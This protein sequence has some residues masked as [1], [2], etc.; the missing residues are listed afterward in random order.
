MNE[1]ETTFDTDDFRRLAELH[2]MATNACELLKAMSRTLNPK[3][4]YQ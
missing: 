4:S 1:L 2:D 3:A